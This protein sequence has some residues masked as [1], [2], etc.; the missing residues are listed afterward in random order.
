VKRGN[1]LLTERIHDPCKAG[2]PMIQ[3]MRATVQDAVRHGFDVVVL[4]EAVRAVNIKAYDEHDAIAAMRETGAA[5]VDRGAF[6]VND[7]A[8]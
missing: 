5:I 1:P 2:G 4:R 8:I 7:R 3:R 6:N